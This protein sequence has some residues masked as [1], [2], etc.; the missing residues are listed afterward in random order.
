MV[1]SP[2]I[3]LFFAVG[4]IAM[5]I[6]HRHSATFRIWITTFDVLLLHPL[7]NIPDTR[8]ALKHDKHII[9]FKLI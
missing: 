7:A 4:S 6:L 1:C 9:R 8:K 2:R 3:N 5:P